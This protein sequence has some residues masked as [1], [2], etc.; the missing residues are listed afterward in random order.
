MFFWGFYLRGVTPG[1]AQVH[2][3]LNSG[4]LELLLAVL[5]GPYGVPEIKLQ[6]ATYKVNILPAVLPFQPL[7]F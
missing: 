7:L 5:G 6:L 1:G 2:L 3:A 4:I